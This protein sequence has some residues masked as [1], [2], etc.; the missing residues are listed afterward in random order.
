MPLRTYEKYERGEQS[1]PPW[2]ELLIL[3]HLEHGEPPSPALTKYQH[4][5]IA[6]CVIN[7]L[8]CSDEQQEALLDRVEEI[9]QESL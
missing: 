9:S 3:D 1:P 8:A 7:K 5:K 2:T 6:V 4:K